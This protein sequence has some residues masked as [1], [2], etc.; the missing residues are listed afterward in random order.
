MKLIQYVMISF[1]IL[2][3]IGRYQPV[4]AINKP[5]LILLPLLGKGLIEGETEMYQ[6]ALESA[7]LKQYTLFSGN[8]VIDA[9]NKQTEVLCTAEYC[10]EQVAMTFQCNKVARGIIK[11][12]KKDSYFLVVK[13]TKVDTDP[14]QIVFSDSQECSPCSFKDVINKLKLMVPHAKTRD[15][16]FV[17]KPGNQTTPDHSQVIRITPVVTGDTRSSVAMVIIESRP[18]KADVYL[19]ETLSGQTPYQMTNLSAGQTILF[20]LKKKDYYPVK[21]EAT[22]KGGINDFKIIDL[23]PKFGTLIIHSEPSGANLYIAGKYAG[24]TPYMNERYPSGSVFVSLRKELYKPL[25]NQKV[26][27]IDEQTT[28]KTYSLKTDFGVL[29]VESDPDHAKV[30]LYDQNQK[31]VMSEKT[32]CKIN[33]RAG[34]YTLKLSKPD[35]KAL[36]FEVRIA[37]NSTE[38][39]T[40]KQAK[41]RKLT[42]HVMV[43]SDPFKRGADIYIDDIKMGK[44]PENIE[45]K[46]GLHHVKVKYNGMTGSQKIDI[47]ENKTSNVIVSLQGGGGMA[48]QKGAGKVFTNSL[49]MK[50]VYI[51]PGRF[52]MGSPS[53]EPYRESDE[54]QHDVIL[55]KGYYLQTT[56]I[57]QGQWQA[58]MGSNP[59][60][61][62]RCGS[63]CPVEKIS[64]ED[65]QVFIKKLNRKEKTTRYRLP[66][67]AEWEYA[68]RAGSGKA[69]ANGGI[70]EKECGLDYNLNKMGWYCGNSCVNYSGGYDCSW[71]VNSCKAGT[72]PVAKKL[73]NRW[74]LY[75]MHGNVYEW[76]QDWYGD[77]SK[78][79]ITDP[80]G[81][82]SGWLRV[83]RGGS[84]GN[85]ARYCRSALRYG[86]EP[87]GRDYYLGLRL[88]AFQFS[89]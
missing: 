17:T 56:E 55:T 87:G 83:V 8:Q 60:H 6:A 30:R 66:T 25:E 52:T 32:P 2:I 80:S 67:E 51:S 82:A 15:P 10:M 1:L 47:Q 46:V 63:D 69:F 4:Q 26:I 21:L 50:F 28:R 20:T 72:H 3:I 89:R 77:Y 37:T 48:F 9:L 58:L 44:V 27:I 33:I 31:Q 41:L 29:I 75:D 11:L 65:V 86:Y 43:T 79:T 24:S 35:Y 45:L 81:P 14:H 76:C 5:R 23:K 73:S 59:S 64:W 70:T 39:I 71:C 40:R 18:D 34:L 22:L 38:R 78:S 42:G 62:L 88:A 84:W 74:G 16:V 61:F 7:L 36:E 53:D 68:A 54:V 49:G 13:I 85:D 19:G 12:I 57:T